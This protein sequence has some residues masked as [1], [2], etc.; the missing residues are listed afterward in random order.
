MKAKALLIKIFQPTAH[1]RMPF[2]YQ[3]RHT[4]P[5]PPY[6][7][8][9]GLLSNLLGIDH[10]VNEQYKKLTACKLSVSGRFE[11]KLTEYIWFRNLS[12]KSH[13][14]YFGNTENRE[15][16]GEVNHIGGQSPMR[17][18]VLENL[19]VNIHLAGDENFL[20]ELETYLHNPVNRLEI[21][22]LGR[23]ED[24]VVFESIKLVEL[25][26]SD[27]DK[28]YNHF[29]WIPQ[30]NGANDPFDFDKADGL[31]YNLPVFATIK[32]YDITYNRHA[33]RS[34]TYMRSKLNDGA[35]TGMEYLY[36]EVS[37][38]PVFFA[39]LEKSN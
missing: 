38:V 28:N 5:I 4:Y 16:N 29:F 35:L 8:V 24:W 11:Q 34:F 36:D 13:E 3:R 15:K 30:H 12:K 32:D 22:H 19:H 9:I 17:I 10:Q 27:R 33:E 1:Y 2:T 6:S 23:A 31:F 21:I 25:K 7:T 18:D 20:L 39:D 37:G 26:K 14:K